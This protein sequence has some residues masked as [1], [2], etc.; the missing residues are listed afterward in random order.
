M[1]VFFKKYGYRH[2][3]LSCNG[4]MGKVCFIQL[5]LIFN[6]ILLCYFERLAITL[7]FA[8]EIKGYKMYYEAHLFINYICNLRYKILAF[9]ILDTVIVDIIVLTIRNDFDRD[10]NRIIIDCFIL[11]DNKL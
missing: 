8:Y 5:S 10:G 4:G 3:L 1:N 2:I 11:T 6:L 7:G 9:I